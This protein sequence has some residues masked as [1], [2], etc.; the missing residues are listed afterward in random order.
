MSDNPN[1]IPSYPS[2]RPN[3]LTPN[4]THRF[5]YQPMYGGLVRQYTAHADHNIGSR[6]Q[7]THS[8][9]FIS[10]AFFDLKFELSVTNPPG[11]QDWGI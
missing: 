7:P 9:L 1:D 5:H 8:S 2:R 3:V 4:T 11:V 6:Q 10:Y